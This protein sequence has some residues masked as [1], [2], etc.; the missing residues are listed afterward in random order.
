M[1]VVMLYPCRSAVF[2][3]K[4]S[5]ALCFAPPPPRAQPHTHTHTLT[6]G[7]DGVGV[8]GGVGAA[9]GPARLQDVLAD[10]AGDARQ[11]GGLQDEGLAVLRQQ[12]GA[13][14]VAR[15]RRQALGL[16][17]RHV[18]PRASRLLQDSARSTVIG[19]RAAP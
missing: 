17:P 16:L 4:A 18:T 1:Y 6:L 7:L 14:L 12:L 5:R 11:L 13:P 3:P 9:R 19:R 2:E 15:E 8:D 10:T